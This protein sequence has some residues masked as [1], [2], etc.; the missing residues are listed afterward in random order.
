MP[1]VSNRDRPRDYHTKSSK[2]DIER[3]ISDDIICGI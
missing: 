1:F 2:S 3:Q